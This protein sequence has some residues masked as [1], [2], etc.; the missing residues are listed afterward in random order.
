MR[1]IARDL[2]AG[3]LHR[4][5]VTDPARRARGKLTI[6]TMHR[7]LP[8][9][10]RRGSPLPSL[11]VTPEEL[12]WL[13]GVLQTGY[14]C[15]TLEAQAGAF[16]RG[17]HGGKPRLA[18]TFDD[19]SWDNFAHAREVLRAHGVRATFF[20]PV[21]AIE[22]RARLSHDRLGGALRRL[23][24]AGRS[25]EVEAL[26]RA[27]GAPAEIERLVAACERLPPEER[28]RRIRTLEASSGPDSHG[29]ADRAM[30]W[31]EIDALR[32]DGHELGSHS[33][34]HPQLPRCSDEVVR[35]E[36]EESLAAL[37][38]R[39]GP[40]VSFCYPDG[41]Y[42]RRCVE[43]LRRAGYRWAVTTRWGLNS[44]SQPPYELS[45]C[46]L[47]PDYLRSHDG[48]FSQAHLSW[49]LSDLRGR[50]SQVTS[51]GRKKV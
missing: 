20:L 37:T 35:Y 2:L 30:T 7:V 49:R 6:V 47:H 26:A 25:G 9:A 48:A 16:A 33:M 29:D 43:A 4:I 42:D 50:V 14:Q 31:E 39:L 44:A 38:R 41:A 13:L 24:A 46:N 45:R 22:K 40:I 10:L 21:N 15:G 12:D 51:G 3:A 8:E 18:V 5:G 23:L 34:S 11:A 1:H 28:E 32:A 27:L 36:I 19:G 17:E